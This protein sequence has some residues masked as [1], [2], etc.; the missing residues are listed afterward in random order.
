MTM[1]GCK[2]QE[3]GMFQLLFQLVA[4]INACCKKP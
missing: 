1:H 4:T 2:T 3:A